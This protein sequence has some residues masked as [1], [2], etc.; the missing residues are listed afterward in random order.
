MS[1]NERYYAAA[2]LQM[3]KRREKNKALEERRRCEV[4]SKLPEYGKLE[5]LL[6]ENAA[7]IV[8]V[9]MAHDRNTAEKIDKLKTENLAIQ[10]N[11]RELLR[12]GGF[13]A[14]YL[15]PICNCKI[16]GDKGYKNGKWCGCFMRLVYAAASKDINEQASMELSSFEDFNLRLY[17][18]VPSPANPSVTQNA[19]MTEIFK[20]CVIFADNFNGSGSGLFM[21]G[22]TGLGKT[23]LS[24]AIANRVI[25]RGYS[26]IY[27][28]VPELLRMLDNEQF[29]RSDG[30]TMSLLTGCDLLIL[31]DLGA[32]N[33]TERNIS[34]IYEII[35]SRIN[36]R[37][38]MIVSTN[39]DAQQIKDRYQ[40][41]I[42]SRLFSMR[43][44]MFVGKDNRLTLSKK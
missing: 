8:P 18:S 15:D 40:D 16:C 5:A 33:S 37:L 30:D 25:E 6:A 4:L 34:Q 22:P 9:I 42:W 13:S 35:N 1:L 14:D 26:A 7:K 12:K 41:R 38:P 21:I 3:D 19:I 43:V 36:R 32:E 39:F 10:K 44:L 2:H 11:M 24:L 28:S 17:P 23:H 27:G 29:G 31:D 20:E